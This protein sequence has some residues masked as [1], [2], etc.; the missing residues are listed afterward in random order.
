MG[1]NVHNSFFEKLEA[2]LKD[3]FNFTKHEN[4]KLLDVVI[5]LRRKYNQ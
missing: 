5:K 1:Y 3:K 2:I 4:Y